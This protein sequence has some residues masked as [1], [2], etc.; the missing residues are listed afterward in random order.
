MFF[1][2]QVIVWLAGI[3][4]MA[5]FA[6]KINVIDKYGAL[7]AVP[8]GFIILYFGDTSWFIVLLLFFLISSLFTKYKYK[9]K[10]MMGLAEENNGARGWRNVL[11]NG[12]PLAAIAILYYISH[13]N[14]IFM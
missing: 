12:G 9:Q 1:I 4:A 5:I 2:E 7:A 3:I 14:P 11:A 6:Y 13:N 10:Q 8:I